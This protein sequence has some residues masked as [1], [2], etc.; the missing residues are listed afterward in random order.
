MISKRIHILFIFFCLCSIILIGRLYHLQVIKHSEL[1]SMA[2]IREKISADTGV[3]RGGIFDRLGKEMALSVQAASAYLITKKSNS[4]KAVIKA[5]SRIPWINSRMIRE[6][7]ARDKGFVWI[8]RRLNPKQKNRLERLDFTEIGFVMETE[9]FYPNA[10]LASQLIGFV[11]TDGKGLEGLEFYFN[12]QLN[13]DSNTFPRELN[14]SCFDP[15]DCY[16][17]KEHS[18]FLTIDLVMQFFAEGALKKTCEKV[19][20]QHGLVI[21]MDTYTGEIYAMANWPGYNPNNFAAYPRDYWRNRCVIDIYEPGSTFKPFW[22]A[23]L[24]E[25]DMLNS[26]SLFYCEN[27]AMYVAGKKI[28]DHEKFGWLSLKQILENSSNIGAIKCAQKLGEQRFYEYIKRFGF[29]E[30]TGIDFPGEVKGILR[31]PD[32]WS[33][34]SLASLAIG[35]EIS[36][37]PIQLIT[38]FSALVNGGRLMKPFIMK[39][40]KDSKGKI[41]LKQTPTIKRRVISDQTSN[42]MKKILRGV[43]S[44]GTGVKA[45]VPGYWIGGKTGT[46]QMVDKKTG[47]YS[48][49]DFLTSFI[50]FF[51]D[52]NAR[53][54]MIVMVSQPRKAC[55][56]GEVAAPIFSEVAKKIIHY[57]QISPVDNDMGR[58]KNQLIITAKL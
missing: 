7:F 29:G 21:I 26:N 20:A 6:A 23:A 48:H 24:L 10:E 44:R 25:E 46:A 13:A 55:W 4:Q 42:K 54:A 34:L 47:E 14:P 37:T 43:V 16:E 58:P 12:K 57:L 1:S 30:K 3:S 36:V 5:M 17:R 56:G 39:E 15:Y 19:H 9:R 2:I 40:I 53:F 52:S 28:R 8:K 27:G 45:G 35:Q 18:L 50:G 49:E 32:D 11:G 22:A 38:A 33:G 41:L 31:A 51:P